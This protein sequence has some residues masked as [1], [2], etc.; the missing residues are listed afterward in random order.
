MHYLTLSSWLK[1]KKIMKNA[2]MKF[3]L[4]SIINQNTLFYESKHKKKAFHKVLFSGMKSSNALD[5]NHC[6]HNIDMRWQF[7]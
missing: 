4:K 1:E 3:F 6:S 7:E 2:I 5:W